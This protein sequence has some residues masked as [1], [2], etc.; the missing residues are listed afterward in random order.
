MCEQC[1]VYRY[2]VC[3]KCG[4]HR[5]VRDV[6]VACNWGAWDERQKIKLQINERHEKTTYY[7]RQKTHT[8]KNVACERA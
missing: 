5:D 8:H 4:S 2:G 7:E 1:V 3:A 6:H